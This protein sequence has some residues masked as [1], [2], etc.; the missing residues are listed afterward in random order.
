MRLGATSHDVNADKRCH[1]ESFMVT[2]RDPILATEIGEMVDNID[3]DKVMVL[4]K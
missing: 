1:K 2:N 4:K 3:E